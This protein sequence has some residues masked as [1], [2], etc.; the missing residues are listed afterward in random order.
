MGADFLTTTP[1][2]VE[3]PL[4]KD[5]YASQMFLLICLKKA[6]ETPEGKKKKAINL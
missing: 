3:R 1:I 6:I 5:S 2:T 4:V